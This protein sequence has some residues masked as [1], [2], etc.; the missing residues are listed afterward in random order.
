L[1]PSPLFR[2]GDHYSGYI[3]K[4]CK[5]VLCPGCG[6]RINCPDCGTKLNDAGL[7]NLLD[8][9]NAKKAAARGEAVIEALAL[10]ISP[11]TGER[12][13]AIEWFDAIASSS[14][15]PPYPFDLV[16]AEGPKIHK[17][18]LICVFDSSKGTP[19]PPDASTR[20]QFL[21][22]LKTAA[23]GRTWYTQEAYGPQTYPPGTN[24]K[25]EGYFGGI[26]ILRQKRMA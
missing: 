26:Q 1:N 16:V 9:A 13:E 11:M 15:T 24:L 10:V 2:V 14:A 20:E 12:A 5:K 19:K 18:T 8:L 6:P 7:Q 17:T 4:T 3:C 22:W 23:G 25:L 21:A